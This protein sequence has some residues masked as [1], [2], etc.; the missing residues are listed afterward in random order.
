[1]AGLSGMKEITDHCKRSESTILKLIREE[2]FPAEKV[3]GIWESDTDLIDDWR[4][5][6]IVSKKEN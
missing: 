4:K 1:M 2:K 3:G 5:K 6:L